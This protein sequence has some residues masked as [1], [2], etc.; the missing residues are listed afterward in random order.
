MGMGGGGWGLGR[1][2]RGMDFGELPKPDI[3]RE[4][5]LRILRYFVPY[6]P[7]ALLVFLCISATSALGLLPPRLI[8]SIIDD[9]LPNR[10]T[11]LL[12][13]LTLATLGVSLVNGL[14]GVGQTYL[15]TWIS[16][17]IMLDIRTQMYTKLQSMSLSF[18][19][20]TKTG[21][22]MSRINNDIGGIEGVIGGT[23]IQTVTQFI[24]LVTT[25][26]V[27]FIMNWKL[28]L[29]SVC[30]LPLFVLPTRKVGRVRWELAGRSQEKMADVNSFLQETLSISGALLTKVFNRE[31]ERITSFRT[32]SR[33]LVELMIKQ[34]MVGRWLFMFLHTFVALGPA[35]IYW[36]GGR[37]VIG[38]ELTTG[39]VVAFV[40]YLNRL[41]G[42]VQNLSNVYVDFIK[43]LALFERIFEYL[44]MKPEV[45]DGD[46]TLP[47]VAG[48][49]SFNNV[50][51][52]YNPD[53]YVLDEVSFTA[54]PGQ[55]VALVG[56]SGSG[57]TT[58]T[59]L[60]ARFYDPLA[61]HIELD[62]YDLRSLTLPSLR[63]NIGVVTQES[64]LFNATVRENLLFAKPDAT[65][66]EL[67]EACK[68]AY[69]FDVVER[70][71][72]GFDTVVGE[73]GFRLSG[74]EKQR[75]AIARVILKNPKILVF[76]E[77]TSS[78]DSVSEGLIQRALTPLMSGR[79]CF[80]VAH[81]LSTILGADM[82][83]VF[84]RGRIV[85]Q[86]THAELLA[87]DG[88]YAKLY[89]EQF[90]PEVS[91]VEG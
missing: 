9:A 38:D 43:S 42:P 27:I 84:E 47:S 19:T 81:R 10:D 61:G 56:P 7:G 2:V 30:I 79:T 52:G 75:L 45:A 77:A 88:L 31:P 18:F 87:A 40:A 34:Q 8:G 57:K 91:K 54:K 26:L 63:R 16:Q 83:L 25:L 44:D 89:R 48:H 35:L 51:F 67:V 72:S 70:L 49:I 68:R 11:R 80:V 36:Y 69:V 22:I 23:V 14:I 66:E 55:T 50:R 65:E 1:A 15:N 37:L 3:S 76:D 28:A 20:T 78:L 74:G 41:Y 71:P 59:Y 12:D 53:K 24:T 58:T 5:I 29:L 62:G 13:I 90:E 32:K 39:I 46:V 73:R 64:Y 21:E 86:G 6:I 33:E 60:L 17:H 82:I 85:G 4:K